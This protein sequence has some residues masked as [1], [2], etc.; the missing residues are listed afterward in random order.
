MSKYVILMPTYNEVENIEKIASQIMDEHSS[1]YLKVID[2]NSPDGTG[3]I[4][5]NLTQKYPRLS[6]LKRQGKEGLGR[7]Y[8]HGFEVIMADP[9]ITH[10][11]MMDADM[12]HNP[13]YLGK[14]MELSQKYD[15]VVG[16]RYTKGGN[17]V[18]WEAWRKLLSFFGNLYARTVTMMPLKDMT[19][20]YNCINVQYLKLIDL[21]SV[22]SS[23]YAFIMELKYAL[24]KAGATIIET[25]I[26]FENRLGGESKISN[27]IISEGIIAPW[28]MLWKNLKKK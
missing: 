5:E 24:Y 12:S 16:S 11:F 14:M 25:P 15:L 23:G 10:V 4:V 3:K 6:V 28:K 7:A 17:T 20:G 9:D 19:G 26:V 22:S 8:T 18:G 1:I 2:D 21:D 27:N 13:A